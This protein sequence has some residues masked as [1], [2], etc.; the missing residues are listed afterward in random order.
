LRP[1]AQRLWQE[2]SAQERR[3]FLQH[4]RP[5]WDVHRHRLAPAVAATVDA[6]QAEGQ[7]RFE[8]GWLRSFAPYGDGAEVVWTT[9]GTTRRLTASRIINCT[10]P[11]GNLEKTRS[12]LLADLLDR[13]VARPDAC[14][15]GLDVDADCHVIGADGVS[16]PRVLAIG[17]MSRGLSG[18]SPPCQT[19]GCRPCS[20]PNDWRFTRR[21]TALKDTTMDDKFRL[22]FSWSGQTPP[23]E[24]YLGADALVYPTLR[25]AV[26]VGFEHR[27]EENLPFI[28]HAHTV[29]EPAAIEVLYREFVAEPAA[30]A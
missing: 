21:N 9:C 5:W 26:K 25:D 15:L 18:K 3:R 1:S 7:V 24:L 17:P 10:G 4:L 28:A 8:K 22:V 2:A 16:N 11:A 23:A 13:G 12:P 30:A 27:D 19:S 14:R 6:M 20:W 29:F